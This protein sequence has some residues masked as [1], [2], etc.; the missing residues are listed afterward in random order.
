MHTHDILICISVI[1][2]YELAYCF[3]YCG[4]V[5]VDCTKVIVGCTIVGIVW[6]SALDFQ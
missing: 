2:M 5:I 3:F 4:K 6:N 1:S